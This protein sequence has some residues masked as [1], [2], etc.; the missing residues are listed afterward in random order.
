MYAPIEQRVF[1]PIVWYRYALLFVIYKGCR[2][3]F[4]NI[5]ISISPFEFF[6][7]MFKL[8]MSSTVN[9]FS[10]CVCADSNG[11]SHTFL[12]TN[13][14]NTILWNAWRVF[15]ITRWCRHGRSNRT[16]SPN[17]LISL[18]LS[19]CQ[20]ARSTYPNCCPYW[21]FI[22]ICPLP[23]AI[24]QAPLTLLRH[25]IALFYIHCKFRQR[26]RTD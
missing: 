24:R 10:C 11:F 7:T 18:M 22:N 2:V 16:F 1:L 4:S 20:V 6:P 5:F 14:T 21:P 8:P 15:C 13:S 9:G 3:L 26:W 25:H 23:P 12:Q 17:I 19:A